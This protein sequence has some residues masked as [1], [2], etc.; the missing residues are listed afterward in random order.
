[1]IWRIIATVC[2]L[3]NPENCTTGKYQKAYPSFSACT[4]VFKHPFEHPYEVTKVMGS[5]F[6]DIGCV[7]VR[8]GG[9]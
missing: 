5:D 8:S 6:N 3:N 1:M 7:L 4:D 9:R 2:M